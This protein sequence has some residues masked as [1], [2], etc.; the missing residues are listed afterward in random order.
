MR[1]W[2][3]TTAAVLAAC[4]A[5]PGAAKSSAAAGGD[6]PARSAATTARPE[7]RT[8]RD[9]I[10][11]CDNGNTCVAFGGPVEGYDGWV[12]VSMAAGPEWTPIVYVGLWG[13]TGPEN[14]AA[15]L[16]LQIDGASVVM[17]PDPHMEDDRIG[18]ATRN[19]ALTII[20]AL[21]DARLVGV[22]K[23]SETVAL[24]AS[25]AAAAL[26]WIDERQGRVNTVTALRRR[27]DR[28][29]SAVPAAPALPAVTAAPAADQTGMSPGNSEGPPATLPA[30]FRNLPAVKECRE[31]L[32]WNPDLFKAV[33]RDRLDADTEL[34][35]VP[36]DAGAYNLMMRFWITG[37]DG[38]NP[39]AIALQG[40]EGDPEY[41]L[42]NPEYDPADR[43][44]RQFAKGRG[45]GDCGVFQKW[46][47]TARGFVLSEES[48]MG[49]CMGVPFDLWPT[50]WR[51]RAG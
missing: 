30:A 23:G 1:W 44:L 34:W 45:I 7:H 10:A 11:A 43:T 49:E 35:G 24:S 36:C 2:L 5:E 14:A 26:L 15:P 16:R 28:P 18:V 9:W 47:W 41:V 32:S 12:R 33:S 4:S 38:V 13:E 27:G 3:L 37:P 20:R 29:A 6:P 51:T 22:I 17:S 40:T 50:H 48:V 46:V 31:N 25:G 39:R 8:F 42:T 21:A 19:D